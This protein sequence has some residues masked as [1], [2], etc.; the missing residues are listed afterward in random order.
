MAVLPTPGS[1]MSTGLFL[2]RRLSTWMTRRISSSRPMTGSS[3]PA[4]ASRREVAAVLLERLV[5]G[6]RVAARSRAGRHARPAA[7]ARMAS[8]PAPAPSRRRCA[9]PPARDV[10]SSRCSVE[11]YSSPRRRASSSARSMSGRT[12]GSRLSWPPWIRARRESTAPSST[13]RPRRHPHRAGAASWPGC[14][15]H[16]ASSAARTCSASSTGLSAAVASCWAARMAS[17]AFWV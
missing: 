16:P 8:W 10:A 12:R 15:R 9:S 13:A 1:P 4:R 2:V 3:L 11:T 6:L 7:R 17:W 14:R 5:G